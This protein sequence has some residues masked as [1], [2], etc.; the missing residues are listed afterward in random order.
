MIL[1]QINSLYMGNFK[2]SATHI[3]KNIKDNI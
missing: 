2:K 1:F 3:L